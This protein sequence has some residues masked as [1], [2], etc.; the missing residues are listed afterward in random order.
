MA[1]HVNTVQGEPFRATAHIRN[2]TFEPCQAALAVAPAIADANA[3]S[4]VIAEVAGT[5]PVAP[6]HHLAVRAVLGP[7][8][9]TDLRPGQPSPVHLRDRLGLAVGPE[10]R[11]ASAGLVLTLGEIDGHGDKFFPALTPHRPCG[12]LATGGKDAFSRVE[13]DESPEPLAS[14]ISAKRMHE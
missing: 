1:V 3:E 10:V 2:E 12:H 9:L 6:L 5:L 4:A 11:A 7:M 8:A 14:D 13:S